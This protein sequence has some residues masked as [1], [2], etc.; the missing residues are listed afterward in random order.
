MLKKEHVQDDSVAMWTQGVEAELVV[1]NSWKETI[2]KGPNRRTEGKMKLINSKEHIMTINRYEALATESDTSYC[3][4]RM[5]WMKIN[6]KLKII[7][8]NKIGCILN[9]TV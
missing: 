8:R 9:R 4:N 6:Q 7:A 5:K 2:L 3:G 1:D